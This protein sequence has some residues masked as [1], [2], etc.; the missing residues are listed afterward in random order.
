MVQLRGTQNDTILGL[1]SG[2]ML[3]PSQGRLQQRD[4]VGLCGL[5]QDLDAI[6]CQSVPV[7]ATEANMDSGLYG[8]HLGK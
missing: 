4:V 5:D 8:E 2:V 3:H 7:L 1:Q 6:E